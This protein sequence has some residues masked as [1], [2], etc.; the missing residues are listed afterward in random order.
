[1]PG[2]YRG[3]RYRSRPVIGHVWHVDFN[4]EKLAELSPGQKRRRII[5]S[6][7][8][9]Y[10]EDHG[11]YSPLTGESSTLYPRFV[12]LGFKVCT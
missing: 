5:R 9:C 7:L 2:A 3:A 10:K 8:Q 12:S 4:P 6:V 11:D 1:M